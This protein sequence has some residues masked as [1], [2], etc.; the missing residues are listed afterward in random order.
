MGIYIDPTNE[1]KESFLNREGVLTAKG[2]EVNWSDIPVGSLAVFLVENLHFTAAAIAY[3]KREF[4]RFKTPD[5]RPIT[6]YFVE[7]NKLTKVCP[8]LAYLV[9]GEGT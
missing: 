6:V 1:S 8:E 5:P 3:T 4:E 2:R 7:T 9:K